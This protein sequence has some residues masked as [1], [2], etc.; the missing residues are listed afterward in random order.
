MTFFALALVLIAAFCHASWNF[1]VKKI[2][3]GPELVWLI[4]ILSVVLYFPAILYVLIAETPNIGLKEFAFLI[5]S[6]ILH[7]GY[8]HLLQKGYA[9]GDLSLVYPIARSTGPLIST[10]FAVLFLNEQMTLQIALGGGIIIFGVLSLTGG[11]KQKMR[12][13]LPSLLFGISA[14]LF[15]G[16]YTVWDAYVVSVLMVSPIMLDYVSNVFRTIFL[17]PLAISRKHLIKK[18]WN[19]HR[20]EVLLIGFLSP[21]AYILVLYAFTFTPV[22]YIAPARETSVL[23]TVLMGSILLGEGDL[24][25]RLFWSVIIL[26][27]VML[28]A[29]A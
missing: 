29:T 24:K 22:V 23:I 21:L 20:Q 11:F 6:S 4:S 16:S 28:L 5:G 25:R 9:K 14:G 7:T 3:G 15:I 18:Y 13:A 19:E 8:F 1:L 26:S 27:G 10:C 17:S 12:H 2:N